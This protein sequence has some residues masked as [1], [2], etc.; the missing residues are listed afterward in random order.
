MN[1]AIAPEHVTL[2]LPL[3][4]PVGLLAAGS[5]SQQVAPWPQDVVGVVVLVECD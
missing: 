1:R 2:L 5:E 4:T 3:F